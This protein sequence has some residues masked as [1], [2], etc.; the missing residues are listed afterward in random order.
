M[1]LVS[2]IMPTRGRHEFA[3]AAIGQWLAQT[4]P[5]TELII[6]DDINCRSFRSE[7]FF[8][9][10]RYMVSPLKDIGPKR[11][12]AC[13]IAAGEV[14]AH[15]DDDDIYAPD[16]IEDQL[17]RLVESGAEITG[18]CPLVFVNEAGEQWEYR[19]GNPHYAPGATLM[20]RRSA[21]ESKPF[22]PVHTGEDTAFIAG[23]NAVVVPGGGH[24]MARIHRGNTSPRA[25]HNQAY[26]RLPMEV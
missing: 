11:N 18:Y 22:T 19:S 14:I 6:L 5:Y 7:P 21:W 8:P 13:A 12:L 2:A 23:R 25:L 4:Y 1:M 10:V 9:N 17:T 16:R 15:W 20:Y 24:M 3:A 26:R